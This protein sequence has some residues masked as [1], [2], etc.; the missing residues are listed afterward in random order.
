ML[1]FLSHPLHLFFVDVTVPLLLSLCSTFL[2]LGSSLEN[3]SVSEDSL[4]ILDSG[5]A[6]LVHRIH[7]LSAATSRLPP[8][9]RPCTKSFVY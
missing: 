7:E 2:H 4:N 9:P 3:I 1:F 5:D 6:L 8:Q